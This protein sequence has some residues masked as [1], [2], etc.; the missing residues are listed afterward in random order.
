MEAIFS[1]IPDALSN[2]VE[3]AEKVEVYDIDSGPIMPKFEIPESFGTEEEYRK[4]FTEKD[5]FDENNVVCDAE[6]VLSELNYAPYFSQTD[7]TAENEFTVSNHVVTLNFK[8]LYKWFGHY[9]NIGI[10]QDCL[11]T[12]LQKIKPLGTMSL[13]ELLRFIETETGNVFVTRYEK[14]IHTNKIHK[15]LDFLN[16]KSP[17]KNWTAHLFYRIPESEVDNPPETDESVDIIDDSDNVYFPKYIPEEIPLVEN[18]CLRLK[19]DDEILFCKECEELGFSNSIEFYEFLLE[20]DGSLNITVNN[21]LSVETDVKIENGT[22]FEIYDFDSQKPVFSHELNPVLGNIHSEILDLGFNTENVKI[23]VD[24]TDSFT[25]IAPIIKHDD[26]S[27]LTEEQLGTIISNWINLEV[28]KGEQIPMI[29]QR[30]NDAS[31]TRESSSNVHGNYWK[32]PLKANDNIDSSN[33]A[34]NTYEYLRGTAYWTAPFSK[35]S[36]E[37]YV[38]DDEISQLEYTHIQGNQDYDDEM[39]VISTPKVGP[40]ETSDEDVY[41]IYNAVALKLKEKRCPE[42]N[43]DVDVKNLINKTFNKYEVYDKVYVKIPGFEKIISAEVEKTVTNPQDIN[44]NKITLNNYNV[45]NKVAQKKTILT[46]STLKY[47]YPKG[48]KLTGIKDFRFFV[49]ET[50]FKF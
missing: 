17:T 21:E 47:T 25:A 16:P 33:S 44:E 50:P 35:E 19:H 13:M 18:L 31:S 32:R 48:G 38:C 46:S 1:D 24:E 28:T 43:I 42:I 30:V 22:V 41:A 39:T 2:T 26:A 27:G 10:I 5:L 20:H 3:I 49:K 12:Y 40:V 29:V 34:N 14:D 11:S 6:E 15:S 9:F 4:K 7:V 23:E 36:D 37:I 45:N 8:A